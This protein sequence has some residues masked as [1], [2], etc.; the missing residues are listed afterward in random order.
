MALRDFLVQYGDL[1]A[2]GVSEA[3][4]FDQASSSACAHRAAE[5]SQP[6]V[7]CLGK[8]P[9]AS[10]VVK[11]TSPSP[12]QRCLRS[13]GVGAFLSDTGLYDFRKTVS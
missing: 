9:A 10:D 6:E 3:T 11:T 7:G 4:A 5:R 1:R 13:T 2:Q 12:E 8:T